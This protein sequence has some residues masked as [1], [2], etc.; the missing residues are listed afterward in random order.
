MQNSK[1][2]VSITSA[3]IGWSYPAEVKLGSLS[4]ELLKLAATFMQ[5]PK[6]AAAHAEELLERHWQRARLS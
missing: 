1:G 3:W 2:T 5:D 4:E 6:L